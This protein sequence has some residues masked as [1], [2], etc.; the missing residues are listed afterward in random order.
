MLY[1]LTTWVEQRVEYMVI[2]YKIFVTNLVTIRIAKDYT[3]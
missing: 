2:L 3:P 1:C